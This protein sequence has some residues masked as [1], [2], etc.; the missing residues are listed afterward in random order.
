MSLN[1]N[2]DMFSGSA[3][4]NNVKY[5]SFAQVLQSV[6]SDELD[7]LVPENGPSVLWR[8]VCQS[9]LNNPMSL[10]PD[11]RDY[12]TLKHNR[13]QLVQMFHQINKADDLPLIVGRDSLQI[14]KSLRQIQ[15]IVLKR[16]L[17]HLGP[18]F[19]YLRVDDLQGCWQM[20]SW[21]SHQSITNHDQ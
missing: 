17:D 10:A 12:C 3:L 21:K 14:T 16:L 11:E 7:Y 5:T 8:L 13:W 15:N 2:Q 1:T 9:K 19:Q 18:K 4:I 20:E 6:S